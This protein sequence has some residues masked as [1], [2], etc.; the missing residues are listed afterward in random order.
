[1]VDFMIGQDKLYHSEM[2]FRVDE[3]WSKGSRYTDLD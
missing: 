3:E 1:V 2:F